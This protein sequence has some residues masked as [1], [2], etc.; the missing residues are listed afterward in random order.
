MDGVGVFPFGQPVLPRVQADRTPK[1]AFVLGDH[2]GAVF[3]RWFSVDGRQRI[4]SVGVASE[5]EA[6]WRGSQEAARGIIA[7]IEI[8]AAAGRLEPASSQLNGPWGET[9][10]DLFLAPLGLCRED[11]WLCDLVPYSCMNDKQ[12][13]ALKREYDPARESLGLLS[14]EWPRLPRVLADTDRRAEIERELLDSGAEV[15]MTLGDGPLK[16]FA[17]HYDAEADL[18]AYGRT[19]EGYGRSRAI[20]VAG[21]QLR[22][23]PLVHPRQVAGGG[24]PSGWSGV[25]ATWV[26]DQPEAV[27]GV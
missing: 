19:P 13:F 5:P 1:R 15:L 25:H 23:L 18:A 20:T 3:A 26:A 21:R 11:S 12:A 22:L 27:P 2:A 16:W 8:P 7:A 17:Q 24:H 6:F 10:D 14:Y 4:G 9:L